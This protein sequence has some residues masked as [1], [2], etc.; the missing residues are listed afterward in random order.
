VLLGADVRLRLESQ[1]LFS[2]VASNPLSGRLARR[3]CHT[4]VE[5]RI[6]SDTQLARAGRGVHAASTFG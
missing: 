2:E 6:M 3:P 4:I 1:R 5:D